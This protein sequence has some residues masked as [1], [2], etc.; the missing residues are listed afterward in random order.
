MAGLVRLP[1]KRLVYEGPSDYSSLAAGRP[2]ATSQGW[3]YLLFEA[4]D[5]KLYE[6]GRIAR[7]NLAWLL[8]GEPTGDGTI[9]A[10]AAG[11]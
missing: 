1:V 4:G 10:W 2:G 7:F 6:D 8:D 9:P 5:R 11:G 3:I